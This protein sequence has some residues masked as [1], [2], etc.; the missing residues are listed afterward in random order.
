MTKL[1]CQLSVY[2]DYLVDQMGLDFT[3]KYHTDPVYRTEKYHTDPVY[4][5][6]Q[7]KEILRWLHRKFGQWGCGVSEPQDSYS[8]S[9]LASVHLFSWLFGSQVA[10]STAQFPDTPAYPLEDLDNLFSFN[11][12]SG[13][14]QERLEKLLEATRNLMDKYGPQKIA[15]P[16]HSPEIDGVDDLENTHC[17]LTIAYQLFGKRILLEMYDNPEGVR[18]VLR[19]IMV[20]TQAVEKAVE[21]AGDSSMNLILMIPQGTS[22]AVVDTFFETG[23]KMGTKLKKNAGFRFV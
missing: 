20:M 1:T 16:F 5:N 13:I 12:K 18:Y 14:V 6:A 4:R 3:E 22:D 11:P 15:V 23:V 19:K 7:W 17:P 9:T 8:P 10:Y 2:P 21:D